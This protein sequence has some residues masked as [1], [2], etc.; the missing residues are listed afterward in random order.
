MQQMYIYDLKLVRLRYIWL[1][2]ITDV[3]TQPFTLFYSKFAEISKHK[4]W[5][6]LHNLVHN[7]S[8]IIW[9]IV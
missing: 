4:K 1:G 6:I 9:K 7:A 3:R 2:Y 8:V 5:L